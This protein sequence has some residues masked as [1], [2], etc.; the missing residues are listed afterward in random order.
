[1]PIFSALAW[2]SERSP[3]TMSTSSQW[4][5]QLGGVLNLCLQS[6]ICQ[7][8]DEYVEI[9]ESYRSGSH[10]G[11]Y[12]YLA[13]ALIPFLRDFIL[14]QSLL[15]RNALLYFF[16]VFECLK[17]RFN[18]LLREQL[19]HLKSERRCIF[20]VLKSCRKFKHSLLLAF[21]NS[22]A[23]GSSAQNADNSGPSSQPPCVLSMHD[24]E[25][26]SI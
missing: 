3:D 21:P 19:W 9:D 6:L 23:L 11:L 8:I 7:F 26:P 15:M 16:L 24:T 25:G 1:M 2:R 18:F 14:I 10:C 22:P 13:F 5:S 20:A 17:R 4:C 12:M